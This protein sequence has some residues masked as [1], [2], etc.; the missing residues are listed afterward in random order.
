MWLRE[1]II[2]SRIWLLPIYLLLLLLLS[3]LL[4][5]LSFPFFERLIIGNTA[6]TLSLYGNENYTVGHLLAGSLL[7]GFLSINLSILVGGSIALFLSEFVSAKILFRAAAFLQYIGIIPPIVFGYLILKIVV[8][9]SE[10]EGTSINNMLI[11]CGTMGVMMLPMVIHE[12][13]K[14]LQTIPYKVREGA[15]SLGASK[16]ETAFMVL[17]PIQLQLFLAVM[18]KILGRTV[19]EILILLLIAGIV[20]EGT[21]VLTAIF[22]IGFLVVLISQF[23]IKRHGENG[24]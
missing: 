20:R 10:I 1:I 6:A 16:Y 11:A 5:Q 23:L 15:Y 7:I 4:Y 8:P 17:L 13:V 22:V 14:I 24:I 18:L 21:E 2:I 3:M 19:S 12:F 9:Y